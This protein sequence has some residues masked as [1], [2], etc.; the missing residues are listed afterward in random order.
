MEARE[1]LRELGGALRAVLA[2]LRGGSRGRAGAGPGRA[3][4]TLRWLRSLSAVTEGEPSEGREPFE[5]P[6]FWDAL[7]TG[8]G[9]AAGV[10]AERGRV[11]ADNGAGRAGCRLRAEGGRGTPC[12]CLAGLWLASGIP[13][14]SPAPCQG[15]GVGRA[16]AVIE[17]SSRLG[18]FKAFGPCWSLAACPGEGVADQGTKRGCGYQCQLGKKQM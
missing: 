16:A 5:L 3:Q 7:G 14:G 1:P 6:R 18:F 15:V 12:R 2:R 4:P 9:A 10:G 11:R 8:G 13:G 17:Q